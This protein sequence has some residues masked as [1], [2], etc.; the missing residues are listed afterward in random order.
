MLRMKFGRKFR[1]KKHFP[2]FRKITGKIQIEF[3]IKKREN[4][5]ERLGI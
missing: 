2:D 1:I 3:K 4:D 5:L